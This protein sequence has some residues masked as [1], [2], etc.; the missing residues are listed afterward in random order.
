MFIN[1]PIILSAALIDSF[2]PVSFALLTHLVDDLSKYKLPRSV[3]LLHGIIFILSIFVIYLVLGATFLTLFHYLITNHHGLIYFLAV[4]III[5][6]ILKLKNYFQK[7]T[8]DLDR[9]PYH[10]LE[11]HK[12]KVHPSLL[13]T[14]FLGASFSLVELAYTGA[15]YLAILTLIILSGFSPNSLSLLLLYLMIFIVPL[16]LVLFMVH[17]G[18]SSKTFLDWY[19]EHPKVTEFW[20]GILIMMFGVWIALFPI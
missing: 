2:N 13:N 16:I 12:R 18:L 15:I 4:P 11:S 9:L 5:A 10:R 14:F 20:L 17:Q 1:I 6:G 19:K 3:I 7:K 8:I